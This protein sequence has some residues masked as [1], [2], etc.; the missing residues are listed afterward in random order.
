LFPD[1]FPFVRQV[2]LATD[3]AKGMGA[4][5]SATE[6]PK[7]A[8]EEASFAELQARIAKTISYLQSLDKALF[9]DAAT[10]SIDVPVSRTE[11]K[12]MSGLDYLTKAAMPNYY[13]HLATAYNILRHNG[14]EIGKGDFLG[15]NI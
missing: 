7:F 1:M 11:V 8:D 13:F 12:A 14:I 4:R 6:N 10:R 9:A 3:F 5:L 2:Q 15:R